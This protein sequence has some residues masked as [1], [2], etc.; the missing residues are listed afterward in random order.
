[1][2]IRKVKWIFPNMKSTE[3]VLNDKIMFSKGQWKGLLF[4]LFGFGLSRAEREL[5]N[6]KRFEIGNIINFY[7]LKWIV[8]F[9]K[10]GYKDHFR[11]VNIIEDKIIF[12]TNN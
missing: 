2:I 5:F 10:N 3:Y 12:N 6:C 9:D 7:F 1:M 11:N 4:H 8:S